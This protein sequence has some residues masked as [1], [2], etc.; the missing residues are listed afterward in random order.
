MCRGKMRSSLGIVK[1]GILRLRLSRGLDAR[2]CRLLRRRTVMPWW[3]RGSYATKWIPLLTVVTISY[4]Y[5]TRGASHRRPR[6][7]VAS[8]PRGRT[9]MWLLRGPPGLCY[10]ASMLRRTPR[11]SRV[12]RQPFATSAAA[13]ALSPHQPAGNIPFFPIFNRKYL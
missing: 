9:T 13:W 10:V 8:L 2:G 4:I 5:L 7:R 6:G 12:S 11:R 3:R 1:L